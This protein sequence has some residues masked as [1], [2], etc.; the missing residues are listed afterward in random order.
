MEPELYSFYIREVLVGLEEICQINKSKTWWKQEKQKHIN[1]HDAY[2]L[3][4][5]TMNKKPDWDKKVISYINPSSS[6]IKAAADSHQ[7]D[8]IGIKC[9]ETLF[10]CKVV[11][12]GYIVS[13]IVPWMGCSVLGLVKETKKIVEIKC[14]DTRESKETLSILLKGLKFLN[15]NFTLKIKHPYYANIQLAMGIFNATNCDFVIL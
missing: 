10:S 2:T 9:Y 3:Y 12:V 1:S 14:F 5:Y 7:W 15:A 13:P 6:K 4:T 8:D 11:K